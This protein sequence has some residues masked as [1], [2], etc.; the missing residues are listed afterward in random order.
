M[1]LTEKRT[2]EEWEAI[3]LEQT[4]LRTVAEGQDAIDL[5]HRH[6]GRCLDEPMGAF[7]HRID[8]DR[9]GSELPRGSLLLYIDGGMFA[10]RQLD[11]DLCF[12]LQRDGFA[13]LRRIEISA[14]GEW[15]LVDPADDGD[16]MPDDAEIS[17]TL[18]YAGI[19]VFDE[20]GRGTYCPANR[21]ARAGWELI[22]QRRTS[23]GGANP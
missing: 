9:Y 2:K 21:Y 6:G 3:H 19:I 18:P 8:T 11:G 12:V 5:W 1:Q 23:R 22:Q 16:A 4:G 20:Q 13:S 17:D 14:G 15:R 10:P 7:I